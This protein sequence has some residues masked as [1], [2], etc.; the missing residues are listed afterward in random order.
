M[1][2]P[3]DMSV[4]R[5]LIEGLAQTPALVSERHNLGWTVKYVLRFEDDVV[6]ALR[7]RA[8]VFAVQS[9]HV[10]FVLSSPDIHYPHAPP[11]LHVT[12]KQ[13]VEYLV[14]RDVDERSFNMEVGQRAYV[15]VQPQLVMGFEPSELDS[16]PIL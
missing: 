16:A 15:Y 5:T 6:R 13:E 9:R 10:L 11:Q 12:M 4:S 1:F 2:R 7:W 8:H 3:S 14:A